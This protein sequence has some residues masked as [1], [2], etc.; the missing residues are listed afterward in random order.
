VRPI[1]EA[2]CPHCVAVA[3]ENGRQLQAALER[4]LVARGGVRGALEHHA[5]LRSRVEATM[6]EF[7]LRT[8]LT[9]LPEWAGRLLDKKAPLPPGVEH[10]RVKM[11]SV[12]N[13]RLEDAGVRVAV[14]GLGYSGLPAE[15][16]LEGAIAAGDSA[17]STLTGWDALIANADQERGL[18]EAANALL[19]S[20]ALAAT[21]LESIKKR[22]VSRV[23]DATVRRARAVDA[24][25]HT[26]GLA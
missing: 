22:D 12:S 18:R 1:E 11:N 5:R 2:V 16:K 25:R 15:S 13:L 14:E 19:A 6:R 20:D 10:S 4:T 3:R 8:L 21:L 17:A 26:L 7:S 24:C 9:P 23:V